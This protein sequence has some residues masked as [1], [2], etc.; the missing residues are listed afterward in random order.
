MRPIPHL[1][2]AASP[3]HLGGLRRLDLRGT[4]V[5]DL[6]PLSALPSLVWVHVGGSRIEDLASL[7]NLSGL[8]VAGREDR[9]S[10]RVAGE[11]QARASRQ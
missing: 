11:D 5:E 6:R 10:P 1:G 4:A 3:A 8:T 9:D 7:D 2:A